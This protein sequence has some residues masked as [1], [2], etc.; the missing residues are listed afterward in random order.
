MGLLEEIV[1]TIMSAGPTIMMPII[2]TI[3]GLA[4][5][6]KPGKVIRSAITVGVGFIGIYMTVDLFIGSVGPAAAAMVDRLGVRLTAFDVG[7]P[8]VSAISWG[9]PTAYPVIPVALAVN[10][11]MLLLGL[12]KTLDIDV[13]NYWAFCLTAA[14][15]YLVTG[16]YIIGIV[17]AAIHCILALKISDWVAPIVADPENFNLPGL[18][19][20]HGNI[21]LA[22][23]AFLIDKVLTKIP[24]IGEIK[25]DPESIRKRFGVLGEP[26]L[27]G[28]VLGIVLGV[29]AG[30]DVW[31]V[32]NVAMVSAATMLL[33]PRMVGILMEGLMPI[34]EGVREFMSKRFPGREIIIGMDAAIVTGYPAVVA[35]ALLLVPISL[36]L[37][38]IMPGN[39]MLPYSDLGGLVFYA[40][41]AVAPS[42]GNI[43]RGLLSGTIQMALIIYIAGVMSPIVTEAARIVGFAIPAE[44]LY[45]SSLD[46]GSNTIHWVI[47]MLL[48]PFY[49]KGPMSW[50]YFD[51]I[52]IIG[53]FACWWFL[54]NEPKRISATKIKAKR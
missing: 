43:V 16:N 26:V 11:A 37:A 12:T 13:W 15:V 23:Y 22:P 33:I 8:V 19:F 48:A 38:V 25:A 24:G 21:M 51:I 44:A 45:V 5:G 41:L 7:W 4:F 9:M 46:A 31:G 50:L 32:A 49:G 18:S 54:R 3:L 30:F 36:I 39:I 40:I 1:G 42:K 34:A 47:T 2:I 20:P 17:A 27:L 52:F 28:F 6:Q 10:I 29:I 53:F 35:V 14:L